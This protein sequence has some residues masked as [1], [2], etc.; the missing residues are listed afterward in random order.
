MRDNWALIYA[1]Q[2]ALERKKPLYVF[3][4]LVPRFRDAALRQYEFM[5]EG[6]KSV[7]KDLKDKN[8][9]F[10][11]VTGAPGENIPELIREYNVDYLVTDFNPLKIKKGWLKEV[12]DRTEITICEVDAHNIVPC[13]EASGKQET[14][15]RTIRPKIQKKLY[16]FLDKFPKIEKHPYDPEK[17][18]PDTDWEEVKKTLEVDTSVPPLDWLKPGEREAA[19][20][21]ENFIKNKLNNYPDDRNDPSKDALSNLSAYLHFGQIPSQRVV[22]EVMD[23]DADEDAK[24]AFIEEIVVRKEL[25]DNFC[26]YN[27]NYDNTECF[28]G[29]AKETLQKHKK[30]KREHIYSLEEFESA[31]THDDLWNASQVQMMET[32]KMHGYM[33]MYWAKKILEWTESPEQAMEFAIYLNDKYEIDG[34]SPNGYTGI[35]WS[36]GGIHDRGWKERPIFGKIRYM[37][38][39][40]AKSKFDIQKYIKKY[41]K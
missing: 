30:D 20:M 19:K 32:G 25:S 23:S 9:P 4:N 26:F 41:L 34:R 35:A 1:R 15:A 31:K 17:Q 27:E 18:G 28:N 37:S 38:Y 33:R 5:I 14:A 39:N 11:L 24:D 10:I 22:M 3:F 12:I 36:I 29:W 6:L 13:W 7:E 8:I 2:K 40:G 16:D 21:L